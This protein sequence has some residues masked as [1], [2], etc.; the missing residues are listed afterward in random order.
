MTSTNRPSLLVP[1]DISRALLASSTQLP[2]K[3]TWACDGENENTSSTSAS[4]PMN[5]S[6]HLH[7]C[8]DYYPPPPPP[9]PVG[10]KGSFWDVEK[11]A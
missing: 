9:S 5:N 2:P 4:P 11:S 6:K 7:P 10:L 1:Q 8:V 3:A